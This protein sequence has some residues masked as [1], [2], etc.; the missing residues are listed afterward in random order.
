M[1]DILWGPTKDQEY[2][3]FTAAEIK[4][5]V[6]EDTFKSYYKFCMVRNPFERLV[7]LFHHKL[8]GGD[9]RFIDARKLNFTNFVRQLYDRFHEIPNKTQI[10]IAHVRPQ[11]E[12]VYDENDKTL[13]D[14]IFK[15]ENYDEIQEFITTLGGKKLEHF[16]STTHEP[17]QVYY[18]KETIA[19]VKLMY[20]KDFKRFGYKFD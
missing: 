2:S 15:Y 10:E 9:T 18:T 11:F 1:K 4:A 17:Y 20:R 13:I 19:M 3:H 8:L 6:P 14:H 12:Y 16:N 5:V 7:S